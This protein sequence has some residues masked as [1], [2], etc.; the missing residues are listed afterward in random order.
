MTDELT[1]SLAKIGNLRVISRASAK[2]YKGARK[3]ML[4]IVREL[5]VD[6]IVDGS[7][8]RSGD[9]VRISVQS[10]LSIC[11]RANTTAQYNN[12]DLC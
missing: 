1:T 10:D 3:P 8:L 5:N 12:F 6:A 2:Q 7:V 11:P 9:R 4:D